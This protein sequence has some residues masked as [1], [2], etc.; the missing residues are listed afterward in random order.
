M[1]YLGTLGVV[2]NSFTV[3]RLP[4]ET[5][6]HYDGTRGLCEGSSLADAYRI[7][8]TPLVGMAIL[9]FRIPFV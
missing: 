5:Y 6:H 9:P 8:S 3:T 7:S 4:R 1:A 2:T